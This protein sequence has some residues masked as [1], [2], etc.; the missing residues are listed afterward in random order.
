MMNQ[1]NILFSQ[2]STNAVTI[3]M[4]YRMSTTYKIFFEL[5][6]NLVDTSFHLFK[7]IN[8]TFGTSSIIIKIF[9]IYVLNL[10]S[11]VYCFQRIIYIGNVPVVVEI[12]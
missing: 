11:T 9:F 2:G 10:V 12:F 1:D 3:C 8:L 7:T 6:V 4:A 5:A